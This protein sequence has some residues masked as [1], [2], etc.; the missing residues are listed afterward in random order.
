MAYS[1]GSRWTG[2]I[3]TSRVWPL[4]EIWT[5][6]SRPSCLLISFG[7]WCAKLTVSPSMATMT[8][9]ALK[10][11][12]LGRVARH[13]GSDVR[14]RRRK[15]PDVADFVL[16][17]GRAERRAWSV[18][19]PSRSISSVT[20]RRA[21]PAIANRNSS[22]VLTGPL[23]HAQDAVADPDIRLQAGA[24]ASMAPTTGVMSRYA[25][26]SAPCSS[27]THRTS[28]WPGRCSWPGRR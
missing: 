21:F 12:L 4:R 19:C 2:V 6:I 27:T 3:R 10:T 5:V 23:V 8:S 17:F 14:M 20:S 11:G 25:G 7:S 26:T 13:H 28:D 24:S 16:A 15:H 9:P 1:F 22:Q 18:C